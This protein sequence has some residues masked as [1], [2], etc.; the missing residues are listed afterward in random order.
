MRLCSLETHSARL[1]RSVEFLLASAGWKLSELGLIAAGLGPGSFTGIRIG[2]ATAL[3]LAQALGTPF[4]GVSCLD[5]LAHRPGLPDGSLHVVTDARRSQVYHAGY[6]RRS[7]R[8]RRVTRPALYHPRVLQE[9][10]RSGKIL[11]IGDGAHLYAKE[12]GL[13]GS[14]WPRLVEAE[15]FLSADIGRL[16]L[17]RKRSWRRGDGLRAEPLYVRPPD[18]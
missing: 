10:L 15:L 12:V 2:V 1:L 18:A 8:V 9:V 3:G 6:L 17:M 13:S 7:G 4:A 5:A 14:A 11:V 16:A